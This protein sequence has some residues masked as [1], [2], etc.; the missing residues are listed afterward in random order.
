MIEYEYFK[1][2]SY[3]SVNTVSYPGKIIYLANWRREINIVLEVPKASLYHVS[4]MCRMN[5]EALDLLK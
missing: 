4:G 1:N 5:M 2:V 3:Y